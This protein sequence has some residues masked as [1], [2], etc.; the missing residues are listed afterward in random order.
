MLCYILLRVLQT[1]RGKRTIV[2]HGVCM[3]T[4]KRQSGHGL[5]F[6]GPVVC[7]FVCESRFV[8]L[9]SCYTRLPKPDRCLGRSWCHCLSLH[10]S[11][12]VVWWQE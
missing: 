10:S 1:F 9:M 11:T 6:C 7:V 5:R 3:V 4:L 2:V 12:E 8:A